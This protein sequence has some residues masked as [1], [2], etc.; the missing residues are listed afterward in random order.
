MKVRHDL[1][2]DLLDG[3]LVWLIRAYFDRWLGL[4]EVLG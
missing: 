4:P 1:D 3:A 2:S